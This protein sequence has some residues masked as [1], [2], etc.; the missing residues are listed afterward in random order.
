[1]PDL[2]HIHELDLPVKVHVA[3]RRNG[4]QYVEQFP[5]TTAEE[6]SAIR[7]IGKTSMW[8]IKH[9][10]D[11]YG[12]TIKG[13]WPKYMIS[14]CMHSDCWRDATEIAYCGPDKHKQFGGRIHDCC[15]VHSRA[16]NRKEP[17]T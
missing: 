11:K 15:N 4:I 6:L 10:L 14:K 2:T 3:L 5:E 16:G 17:W 7:G 1:M 12:T 13:D 9:A 8:Y